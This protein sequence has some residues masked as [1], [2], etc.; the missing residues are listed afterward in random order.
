MNNK[1]NPTI[2]GE[3]VRD[4]IAYKEEKHIDVEL[5]Y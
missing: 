4:P 3:K 2:E 1:P 5:K